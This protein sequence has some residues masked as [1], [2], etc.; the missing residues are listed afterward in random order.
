MSLLT[1]WDNNKIRQEANRQKIKNDLLLDSIYWTWHF[2]T[3]FPGRYN[4]T[5]HLGRRELDALCR[6]I[7]RGYKIRLIAS[8]VIVYRDQRSPHAH[9]VLTSL[10][11]KGT[12]DLAE[13]NPNEIKER[14]PYVETKITTFE[15]W[16][17]EQVQGYITA[18][19]NMNLDGASTDCF[20]IFR[21]K[22]GRLRQFAEKYG[23]Q[24][25]NSL[26]SSIN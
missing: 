23:K 11:A 1:T 15:Q 19:H 12:R 14:W 8:G 13:I 5:R 25:W 16:T 17:Q 20:D 21:Y 6:T 3:Q 2:T 22:Y 24:N 9:L 10:A 4:R 18:P 26:N 7:D